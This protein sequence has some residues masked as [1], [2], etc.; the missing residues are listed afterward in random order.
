[1][2]DDVSWFGVLPLWS[3]LHRWLVEPKNFCHCVT[4]RLFEGAQGIL[5]RG[6]NIIFSQL[7]THPLVAICGGAP[8]EEEEKEKQNHTICRFKRQVEAT[9]KI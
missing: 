2:E 1:M 6:K 8:L 5:G 3:K 4:E 7:L 9:S